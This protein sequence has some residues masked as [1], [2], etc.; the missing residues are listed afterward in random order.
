[1]A[2][3]SPAALPDTLRCRPPADF[4]HSTFE[5]QLAAL[6]D[7]AVASA[8]AEAKEALHEVHDA[9]DTSP[10]GVLNMRREQTVPKLKRLS[11]GRSAAISA[12]VNCRGEVVPEATEIAAAFRA[13]WGPTFAHKPIRRTVLQKWL[14]EDADKPQG[15]KQAL[16]SVGSGAEDVACPTA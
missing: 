7:L 16:C 10:P 15:L 6:R 1:M 3:K 4:P 9:M 2:K 8:K 11:P 5:T 12:T 13:H 14:Q